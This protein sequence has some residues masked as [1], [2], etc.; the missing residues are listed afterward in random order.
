LGRRVDLT[1][2]GK[3][4]RGVIPLKI[5]FWRE[6][7]KSIYPALICGDGECVL[8]DCGYRGFLPKLES[9]SLAAGVPFED[10]TCV[11]ITHH[12][13][14]HC[15]AL[16]E[17]KDKYPNV[18]VMSS[19]PDALVLE[20]KEKSIRVVQAQFAYDNLPEF[21]K[22]RAMQLHT[23]FEAIRPVVVDGILKEGDVLPWCGGTEVI[24]TPGHMPGHISLFVE[25]EKTVITGDALVALEGKLRVANSQYSYDM[26]MA[27][28][29]A[30][31]LLSLG[32]ERFVCYHGGVVTREAQ[33]AAPEKG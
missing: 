9:A 15:G 21:E 13:Y 20:G 12:D 30:R 14:D 10:V 4:T 6:G 25:G 32:A 27:K 3:K 1:E 23:E 31:T 7:A 2:S 11:V 22:V 16:A 26:E 17:I 29:S 8:V 18:H 28:R 19:A 5:D 33:A 24:A